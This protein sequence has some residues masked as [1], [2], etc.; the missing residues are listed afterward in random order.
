MNPTRDVDGRLRDG[1]ISLM[2]RHE[3]IGDVRSVGLLAGVELVTHRETR[4]PATDAAEKVL[5]GMREAGV[6]IGTAGREAKC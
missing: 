3:A 1:L 5:N 6:L 4:E 2:D